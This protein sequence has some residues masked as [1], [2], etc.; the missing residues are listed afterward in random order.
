MWSCASLIMCLQ[1]QPSSLWLT[2][3]HSAFT[4]TYSAAHCSQSSSLVAAL[5]SNATSLN[6]MSFA[7]LSNHLISYHSGNCSRRFTISL[8]RENPHRDG[9][10]GV[11]PHTKNTMIPLTNWSILKL[12]STDKPQEWEGLVGEGVAGGRV[13]W[14][15]IGEF[16]H[17]FVWMEPTT[18]RNGFLTS[19]QNY[20]L[21]TGHSTRA[22]Q[23]CLLIH[24][25]VSITYCLSVSLPDRQT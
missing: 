21:K 16:D 19:S 6:T 9:C 23:E 5:V 14:G 18:I 2:L 12:W 1:F 25:T 8:L 7:Y 11:T 3:A 24:I 17:C 4:S 22:S 10:K 20:T 15:C 13:V